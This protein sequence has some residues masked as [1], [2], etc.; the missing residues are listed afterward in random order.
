MKVSPGLLFEFEVDKQMS[1]RK[2]VYFPNINRAY[3]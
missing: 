1:V 3:L 2:P